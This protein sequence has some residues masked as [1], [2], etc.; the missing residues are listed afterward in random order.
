[1]GRKLYHITR[2]FTIDNAHLPGSGLSGSGSD[3]DSRGGS[4]EGSGSNTSGSEGSV[5][6]D[7]VSAGCSSGVF[8]LRQLISMD[9]VASGLTVCAIDS[10][11][12]AGGASSKT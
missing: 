4:G 5:I 2:H 6:V 9:G 12:M 1:M 8:S 10:S 11:S 3:S 7:S